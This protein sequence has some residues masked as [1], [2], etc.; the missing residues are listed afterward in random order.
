MAHSP[1]SQPNSTGP[2]LL[3]YLLSYASCTHVPCM[4]KP[5]APFSHERACQMV[6][7]PAISPCNLTPGFL[8]YAACEHDHPQLSA[9]SPVALS[10]CSYSCYVPSLL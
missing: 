7:K 9:N 6:T 3:A 1:D 2:G 8:S 4:P 5:V 10:P